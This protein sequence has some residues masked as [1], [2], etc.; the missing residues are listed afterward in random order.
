MVNG[1]L[2]MCGTTITHITPH[3]G[4]QKA[5]TSPNDRVKSMHTHTHNLN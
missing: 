5:I 3:K 2:S 4:E 1:P